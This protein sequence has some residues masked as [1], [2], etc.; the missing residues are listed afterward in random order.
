MS[1]LRGRGNNFNWSRS[2][3]MIFVGGENI[4]TNYEKPE[5]K[6]KFTPTIYS[7]SPR[8]RTPSEREKAVRNWS[9]P[10]KIKE[11]PRS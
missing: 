9:W 5:Q 10:L 2:G 3:S 11:K 4:L 8:R 7:G 6:T 1:K